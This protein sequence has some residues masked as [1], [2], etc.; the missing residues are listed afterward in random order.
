MGS[1]YRP[2][3]IFAAAGVALMAISAQAN[4]CAQLLTDAAAFMPSA[5]A[6]SLTQSGILALA[7]AP[8]SAPQVASRLGFQEDAVR[9]LMNAGVFLNVLELQNGGLY[10]A[11][12]TP[13]VYSDTP[14]RALFWLVLSGTAERIAAAGSLSASEICGSEQGECVEL[15]RESTRL[16]FVENRSGAFALAPHYREYLVAGSNHFIGPRLVHFQRVMYP[17]YSVRGILGALKTGRSQWHEIF[18]KSV[19]HPFDLYSSEPQLL[20]TFMR[21]MHALNSEDHPTL[22]RKLQ[23]APGQRLLDIGGA[24]GAWALEV[25]RA[26]PQ[27]GGVD[28][29]ELPQALPVLTK[30]FDDAATADESKRIH[31]IAGSF[32]DGVTDSIPDSVPA[33][34]SQY[35]HVSLG[36][37]L[38]DWT[39]ETNRQILRGVRERLKPGGTLALLE[40]ILPENR[41]SR[42]TQLDIAMLLQTEGRERTFAEYKQMLEAEGFVEVQWSETATRRQLITAKRKP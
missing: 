3:R 37:I 23:I 41:V 27:M 32:L 9:R 29:L 14:S 30:I 13:A 12:A 18:G 6:Q 8:V 40:F 20:E 2:A 24:S 35:D 38:H 7:K 10:Q 19:N 28:I 42:A 21:G 22:A 36:W 31:F 33:S 5:I 39:D 15:L 26:H 25:L 11:T 16:G 1:R 34:S 17:M 4:P